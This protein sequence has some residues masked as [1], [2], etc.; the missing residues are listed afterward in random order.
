MSETKP[1]ELRVAEARRRDVGRGIARIDPALAERLK[2]RT[3]DAI[4]I[5]GKKN[6]AAL[7]WSGYP[8][9]AGQGTIRIDAAIR[10]NARVGL[11]EKVTISK[12]S[13]SDAKSVTFAPVENVSLSGGEGYLRRL[14]EGRILCRGD[15]LLIPVM[16]QRLVL[17]VTKHAP[18]GKAAIMSASTAVTISDKPAQ[19]DDREEIP[20]VTYD[21]IGGLHDEIKKVR[22]MI[23]LPMKHPE[24]FE[25]L[26]IEPPK[27]VLLYGPPGTG[28]T[29][30]A[31]AVASETEANFFSIGGPEI[32]SKFYG[33]SE[34]KLRKIF[35]EAEENAPSIIFID[36][37]DSIAPKREDV[38]GEVERRVVAQLL[39]LMDGLKSRGKVIVIGAT[40]RINA[41]DPALRRPGRFDREIEL[42]IPNKAE[43]LEILHV[44]VRGVPLNEDVDVE[45]LSTV[46]HGF[47]GADLEALVKEAAMR[48]LRRTLPNI[49]LDADDIS[50]EVLD[51]LEVTMNDFNDSLL[52]AE[53]SALRELYVDIPDVH[54]ADIGGL[55][56]VK[57]QLKEAVEWPLKYPNFFEYM[58][59]KQPKGVLLY[60]PP[61]TGKTMLAKAV[62]TESE[63]N[64]ISVKGPEF[65]SK[66]VGESER[67]IRE[68]F[69]KAR[70]AAPTVIFFD[71]IDATATT[72]STN[73]TS[74]VTERVVS[75]LLTEIDGLEEL[76]GVMVIAAS[77]RP[78][79]IDPALLRP[80]RFD[81]LISVGLPDAETREAILRIHVGSIPMSEDA[82][83]EHVAALTDTFSGAE[84][85]SVV[86]EATMAALRRGIGSDPFDDNDAKSFE[87]H[88]LTMADIE[89]ATKTVK[90]M[91]GKE[92]PARRHERSESFA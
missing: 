44:H 15:L 6:T 32:M 75:Q 79:L 80:G 49:D 27:G 84:L 20:H 91:R 53:P 39:S 56:D 83:L 14:L 17:M 43:R 50:A 46:T 88:S 61:G 55:E 58:G 12:I 42:G 4:R 87:N 38:T 72:R 85:G 28:K 68:I 19:P 65:L 7:V 31:R 51:S 33:E 11:D 40:N 63:A 25:R 92:K 30:L 36:E 57:S 64:F 74:N 24:L 69:R 37:I 29:L 35:E 90:D 10:R 86:N 59:A 5:T 67:A 70:S 9:D 89:Q 62:A 48:A 77:N 73:S 18:A 76:K 34:G 41:I 71:E 54:W 45:K 47:V 78:E 3:G 13:V 82:N 16:N 21:E 22:E 26:G 2:L 52:E 60:G 66:W 1:I 8:E 81:R 23:E